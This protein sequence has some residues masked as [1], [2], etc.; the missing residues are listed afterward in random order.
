MGVGFF[1][2]FRRRIRVMVCVRRVCLADVPLRVLTYWCVSKRSTPVLAS[3]SVGREQS[4]FSWQAF[5]LSLLESK[6]PPGRI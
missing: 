2:R 5:V 4:A 3:L 6:T 1:V